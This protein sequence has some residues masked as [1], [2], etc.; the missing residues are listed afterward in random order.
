MNV[1]TGDASAETAIQKAIDEVN[2]RIA[3]GEGL[4]NETDPDPGTARTEKEEVKEEKKEEVKE[5]KKEE[6]KEEQ[7]QEQTVE[8]EEKKELGIAL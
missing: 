5:E 2:G 1:Y 6:K 4:V 3:A 8:K 7:T